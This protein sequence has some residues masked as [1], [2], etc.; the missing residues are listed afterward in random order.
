MRFIT[1]LALLLVTLY[2]EDTKQKAALGMGPY[3]QT[4]PY[5]ESSALVV[6][7]PVLF[8]DNSLFYLRWTRVGVYFLGDNQ[9]EYAW[10]FSLT[11]QPRPYGYKASD[12]PYLK[13]MH[14]RE[15]TFEG[16]L[17]FSATYDDTFIEIIALND[18]FAKH[19]AWNVRV[20]IGKKFV[21]GD[22]SLYPI[23]VCNY[24]SQNF[25]NYYYGV[26]ASEVDLDIG[27]TYYRADEGVQIA[28]QTFLNYKI[29]KN[30]STLLNF[31]ADRLPQSAQESPLTDDTYIY[32]GLLSLLYTFE[33]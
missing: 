7:S 31:R 28:A 33:Y 2:A 5:K 32:S 3:I 22:L 26:E 25:L 15:S 30:F 12:S 19:D 16:G 17:A 20:E 10:G 18:L 4:Q 23:L 13:G 14:K 6:P 1:L 11:A 29:D 24:F 8:F 27:R 9:E 21:F